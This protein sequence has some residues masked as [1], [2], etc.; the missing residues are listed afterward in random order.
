MNSD[1]PISQRFAVDRTSSSTNSARSSN[2]H[3]NNNHNASDHD[4]DDDDDDDYVD[5]YDEDDK[6]E[7][8]KRLYKLLLVE[9]QKSSPRR[10]S[11]DEYW[12]DDTNRSR[13]NSGHNE[14]LYNKVNQSLHHGDASQ[15]RMA[16]RE[17]LEREY[18]DGFKDIQVTGDY[19]GYDDYDDD[20]YYYDE[21]EDDWGDEDDDD[22]YYDEDEDEDDWD[23]DD[24]DD[25]DDYYY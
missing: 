11:F 19:D 21:D 13:S 12:P 10:D 22:Y 7:V 3:T 14:E 1:I 16:I 5:D 25:D 2:T 24:D 17:Q 20:D 18:P 4:Y 23:D 6:I 15:R 9:H 8:Q